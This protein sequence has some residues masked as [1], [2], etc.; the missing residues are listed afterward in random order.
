MA[1]VLDIAKS[2]AMIGWREA[3]GFP[4]SNQSQLQFNTL[5]TLCV[6]YVANSWKFYI[7][8]ILCSS[9]TNCWK[10]PK[11]NLMG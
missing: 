2:I 7:P 9:P 1:T 3:R 5:E 6:Y 8:W 11:S 4:N 10:L